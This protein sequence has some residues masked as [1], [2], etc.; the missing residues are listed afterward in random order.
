MSVP[1]YTKLS[2]MPRR[3]RTNALL[4]W[5]VAR[6]LIF[7]THRLAPIHSCYSFIQFHA[8]GAK[9]NW[10]LNRPHAKGLISLCGGMAERLKAPVLKT[11]R[12]QKALVGS[13][14]TPSVPWHVGNTELRDLRTF[15]RGGWRMLPNAIL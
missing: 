9:W 6:L 7:E 13:N 5:A 15:L 11:G 1:V 2:L 8:I 14:P 12:V 3:G 10:T 4:L